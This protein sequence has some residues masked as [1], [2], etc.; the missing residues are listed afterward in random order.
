MNG[1]KSVKIAFSETVLSTVPT[2]E[3]APV[4]RIQE[5]EAG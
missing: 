2:E 5:P 1:K 4:N 3:L